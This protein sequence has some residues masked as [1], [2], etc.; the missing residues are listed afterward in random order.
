MRAMGR[1]MGVLTPQTKGRA[2]GGALAAVVRAQ[3]GRLSLATVSDRRRRARCR[4]HA[5]PAPCGRRASWRPAGAF[6]ATGA[7]LGVDRRRGSV[8]LGIRSWTARIAIAHIGPATVEPWA[9][10]M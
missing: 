2:D 8:A 7:G 1:V 6:G 3:L 4:G 5:A 9:T 10:S